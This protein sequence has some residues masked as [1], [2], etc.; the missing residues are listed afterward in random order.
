MP[1]ARRFRLTPW[2][3]VCLFV[4]PSQ[5]RA[6]QPFNVADALVLYDG[7][8]YLE[9]S[10]AISRA[11]DVHRLFP[12]F[13]KEAER[14]VT[15]A[16]TPSR[17]RRTLVSASVALELAHLLRDELSER[18]GRYLVWAAGLMRKHATATR[19][20]A[21]RLWYLASIAGMQELDDPWMLVIGSRYGIARPLGEGGHLAFATQRF[22][23][24][25]RFKLARVASQLRPG[26]YDFTPSYVAFARV[27]ATKFIPEPSSWEAVTRNSAFQTLAWFERVQEV[28]QDFEA[29]GRID[30]IRADV[31]LS[32]GYLESVSMNW[33]TA[34]DHLRR[35]P[36]LTSEPHLLYLSQYFIGRTHQHMNERLSAMDAFE[37]T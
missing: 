10:E 33:L 20:P 36:T 3:A 29:L 1:A 12:T 16:G 26:G 15:A 2:L 19:S 17:W 18:A 30:A 11:G 37:S 14:W 35:V 32:L 31:E 7:G 27:R 8:A 13:K 22:P 28:Q 4:V 9:F 21:E 25:P 6:P 23:D 5:A 24:E 34:L